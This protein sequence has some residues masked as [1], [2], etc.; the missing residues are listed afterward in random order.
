[1]KTNGPPIV[2]DTRGRVVQTDR[3]LNRAV[4]V[5]GHDPARFDEFTRRC[6]AELIDPERA[7]ALAKLMLSWRF[8]RIIEVSV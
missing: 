3:P 6:Q 5:I 7:A 4:Q 8:G 1:M 2:A